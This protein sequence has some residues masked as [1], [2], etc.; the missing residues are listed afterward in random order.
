MKA[1]EMRKTGRGSQK[2]FDEVFRRVHAEN[3]TALA[4]RFDKIH[5]VER[6]KKAGSIDA[7]IT[8]KELRPYIVKKIEMASRGN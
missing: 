3:Q 7:I 1:E 6:A 8:V 4:L 5:S 2:D